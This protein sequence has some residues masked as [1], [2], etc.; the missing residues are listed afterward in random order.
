MIVDLTNIISGFSEKIRVVTFIV[1]IIILKKKKKLLKIID[2]RTTECPYFF[3]NFL[4]IKGFISYNNKFKKENNLIQINTYNSFPN[5]KNCSLHN[6][7]NINNQILLRKWK[8]SYKYL[9][10]KNI[11][12]KK[13][14]LIKLPKNYLSIH[15]RS[16]DRKVNWKNFIKKLNHKDQIFYLQL[17]FFQ[18]NIVRIIKKYSNIRN[19]FVSSDDKKLKKK[20][21]NT[22]IKNNFNV[23][24]N[25]SLFKKKFRQTSGKDFIIDLFCI[26][27]S[28]LIISTTG[29]GVTY[30]AGL[31]NKKTKIIKFIDEIN[32][33]YILRLL[34]LLLY[35]LKRL[36]FLFLNRNKSI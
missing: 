21:I 32:I 30:T 8:Y 25:K 18:K 15:L 10:P 35:Y 16:T 29:G 11:I 26:A 33:L 22:L 6:K 34:F 7:F 20:V 27:K 24:Y 12:K 3:N 9:T 28:R 36:K 2:K 13:I 5:L 31:I 17:N 23:Y 1:A 14:K 4:K 19:I